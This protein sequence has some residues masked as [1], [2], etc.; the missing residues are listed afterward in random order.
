MSLRTL[1]NIGL[2]LVLA[3]ACGGPDVPVAGNPEPTAGA[4]LAAP[5]ARTVDPMAEF[6]TTATNVFF[7]YEDLE[8]AHTF[9]KE[10]SSES[11]SAPSAIVTS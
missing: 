4:N 8:R 1:S 6:G 7:Y 5:Q 3:A 2:I 10:A 9:Y 11:V